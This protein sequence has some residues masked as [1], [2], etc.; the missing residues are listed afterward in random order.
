MGLQAFVAG[1]KRSGARAVWLCRASS[2]HTSSETDQYN[3]LSHIQNGI[4]YGGGL[5]YGR[6]GM[7]KSQARWSDGDS[8]L[9]GEGMI[10]EDLSLRR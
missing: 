7:W 2:R 8:G 5:Q 3:E 9:K 6:V 4:L 10:M 1:H